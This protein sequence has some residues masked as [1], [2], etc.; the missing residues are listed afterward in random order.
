MDITNKHNID[1]VI[2]IAI[3]KWIRKDWPENTIS[4]TQLI[5]TPRQYQLK[6][7][8]NS[9]IVT[10]YSDYLWIL[11][12]QTM[13]YVME[14]G[15]NK[16]ELSEERLTIGAMGWQISGQ[17]DLYQ[18]PGIVTDYKTTSAYSFAFGDKPEWEAQLNLYALLLSHH[19]FP[20][21]KLRIITILR[22][23]QASKAKADHNY[24]QVAFIEREVKL[25]PL[26]QQEKYLRERITLHQ[27]A[28]KLPD[29]ELP[30]CSA[31]ERWERPTVYAV[32]KFRRKSA[33]KLFD[34]QKEALELIATDDKYNL[35]T[36]PG[37]S[38]KC[39][40]YCNAKEFC[41]QYQ[42][43]KAFD[44]TKPKEVED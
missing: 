30:L 13:H 37:K 33:V 1:P 36:R 41:N 35:Q 6:K 21:N 20:V 4:V 32:M 12:G 5:S 15:S 29:N 23:W 26:V 27:Q 17:P 25:W 34:N 22:D 10:D 19:N 2:C 3:Q 9:L 14:A 38:V 11:L 42:G 40:D 28:E 16:N 8:F 39:E 7:R 44:E 24:P 31:E 18:E 43:M